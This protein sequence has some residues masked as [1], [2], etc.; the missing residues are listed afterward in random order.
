MG[1]RAEE[2]VF[3]YGKAKRFELNQL[4]SAAHVGS[5]PDPSVEAVAYAL[6]RK[7]GFTFL[8]W[9]GVAPTRTP[10]SIA[11]LAVSPHYPTFART[12]QGRF[13]PADEA[14]NFMRVENVTV[15]KEKA[16]G[17]AK[18]TEQEF[19]LPRTRLPETF[20]VVP[21]LCSQDEIY[22]GLETKLLPALETRGRSGRFATI[23][24]WRLSK[25][26]TTWIEAGE[27]LDRR[28]IED[29]GLRAKSKTPLGEGY[30]PSIA[31]NPERVTPFAVEV[32]ASRLPKDLTF[33]SLRTLL[34]E[35]DKIP[36]LHTQI[37]VYRF[38]HALDLLNEKGT[39]RSGL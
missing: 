35:V 30:F 19:S 8:S 22:V 24:A 36:D 27:E 9:I 21:Y 11:G 13:V 18:S 6:G 3:K 1:G 39:A 34:Q 16:D 17:S 10:Q 37:G 15:R 7:Y 31:N 26:S 4:I 5:I 20:S 23:P 14:A 29:F 28:M 12:E 25:K 33:V 32:D 2:E 38:A